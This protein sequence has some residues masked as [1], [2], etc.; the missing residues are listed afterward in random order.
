MSS[1]QASV[2]GRERFI[3]PAPVATLIGCQ[4]TESGDGRGVV[5]LDADERHANP[6]G[7]VHGGILCDIADLAMGTAY[8]S[9]LGEDESF[10]TIE[11]KVNFLRPVW[12]GRLRAVAEVKRRGRT[13]GLVTCDVFDERDQSVAY[14]TSTCMTLRGT[15]ATGR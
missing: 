10:T 5:E 13:V 15:Q 1:E 3:F 7:T 2:N 6:M 9:T 12:R 4:V 8:A 14:F 11:L